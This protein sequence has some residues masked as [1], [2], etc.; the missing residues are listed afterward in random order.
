MNNLIERRCAECSRDFE[1][2]VIDALDAGTGHQRDREPYC[3]SNQECVND[4][5][6]TVSSEDDDLCKKTQN[7]CDD[8]TTLR[9][10]VKG[11][12]PVLEDCEDGYCEDGECLEK[13]PEQDKDVCKRTENYC[14]DKNNLVV[15]VKG[16]KAKKHKCSDEVANGICR[17]AECVADVQKVNIGDPC[18]G[19]D[20][21]PDGAYCDGDDPVCVKYSTKGEPCGEVY[22]GSGLSCNEGVC[23]ENVNIGDPCGEYSLCN[24]GE[25]HNGLCVSVSTEYGECGDQLACPQGTVCVDNTCVPTKG[26]CTSNAECN[27]DSYCCLHSPWSEHVRIFLHPIYRFSERYYKPPAPYIHHHQNRPGKHDYNWMNFVN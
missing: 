23:F 25:C 8:E 15:C 1:I 6:K 12:K 7:T 18:N 4:K 27:G 20:M 10:C 2:D 5:C 17:D 26:E 3:K 14:S 11:K 21:C 16:E 22:C 9:K 19:D 13:E 24:S